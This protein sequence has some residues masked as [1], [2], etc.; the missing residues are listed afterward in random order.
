MLK[1]FNPHIMLQEEKLKQER[2]KKIID[3]EKT[4]MNY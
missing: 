2:L 4:E 3:E 1:D